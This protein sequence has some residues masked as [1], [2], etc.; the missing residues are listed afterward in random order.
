MQRTHHTTTHASHYNTRL[1][2]FEYFVENDAGVSDASVAAA[3]GRGSCVMR[4]ASCVARRK[5]HVTRNTSHVARDTQHCKHYRN[6]D[7]ASLLHKRVRDD[8]D[9]DADDDDD[10]DDDNVGN[11]WNHRNTISANA[12]TSKRINYNH[13]HNT[14]LPINSIT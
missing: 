9:D 3:A 10:D 1:R 8:D 11:D 4:H 5:L 7:A 12:T 2:T 14:L 13:N 6:K